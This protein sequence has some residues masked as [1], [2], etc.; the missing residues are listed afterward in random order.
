MAIGYHIGQCRT[1][2]SL[3]K[4]LLIMLVL[5]LHIDL[6][7]LLSSYKGLNNYILPP[8]LLLSSQRAGITV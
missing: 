1:F 4:G 2:L 3:R 8:K 7:F 6:Y 5:K